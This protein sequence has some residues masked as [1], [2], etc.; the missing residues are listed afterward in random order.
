MILGSELEL[1]KVKTV[2][3]KRLDTL[4][5]IR[6]GGNRAKVDVETASSEAMIVYLVYWT[7]LQLILIHYPKMFSTNQNA[8]FSK[9][10][11]QETMQLWS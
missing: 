2:V 3:S 9:L 1:K 8:R 5:K 10:S 4:P 7:Y 11:T 6:G